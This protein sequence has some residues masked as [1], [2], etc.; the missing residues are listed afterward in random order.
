MA[1]AGCSM[2]E[3]FNF[4]ESKARINMMENYNEQN[5]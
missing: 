5:N 1:A 3:Y 2:L 4:N